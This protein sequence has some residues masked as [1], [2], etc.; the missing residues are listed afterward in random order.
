MDFFARKG[1]DLIRRS[2]AKREKRGIIISNKRSEMKKSEE[3]HHAN[4]PAQRPEQLLRQ[5]RMRLRPVAA[6]FSRGRLRRS[7]CAPRHR[8][9]QEHARQADGCDHRRGHLAGTAEVP[10]AEGRAAGF[11]EIRALCEDDARN[12]RRIHRLYRAL[13]VGRGVAGRD[14]PRPQRRGDRLGVAR[15]G[16][17]GAGTY[18][19]RGRFL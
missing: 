1:N 19:V 4:H 16:E 6:R 15:A 8:A 3:I 9:G 18:A 17:G 14:G 2:I 7:R 11:P 13:R 10:G 12:L 5:R